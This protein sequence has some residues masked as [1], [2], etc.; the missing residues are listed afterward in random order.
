MR[1]RWLSVCTVWPSH[2][3]ISSLSKA[4]LALGKARSRIEPNMGCRG[5]DRLEW[6]DAL[7]KKKSL[8]EICRM[9]RRIVM[10]KLIC[11]F[12]HCECDGHTVHTLSQLPLTTDW[13]APRESDCSRMHSKVSSDWLPSYIKATRT[14]LEIFKTAGYFP[15]SP[16][17]ALQF[18]Y[19]NSA[20]AKF[21][22]PC[23]NLNCRQKRAVTNF[24]IF[25][26]RKTTSG[27]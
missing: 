21:I 7:P 6:R 15:D 22:I 27:K 13:L 18:R 9:D 8:R 19:I 2:S 4:I 11:S 12:G 14:V 24:V 23:P 20:A 3:Q 10:K 5:P 1:R 25:K 16:Q 17:V 26:V